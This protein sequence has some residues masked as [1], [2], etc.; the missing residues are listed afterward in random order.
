[1]AGFG[2]SRL[3][4]EYSENVNVFIPDCCHSSGTL[5]ALG[6]N[7]IH[8]SKGATLSPIDPSITGPLNPAVQ[9]NPVSAPQL[10]PLSVESVAGYYDLI[11]KSWRVN[12]RDD[13]LKVLAEKVHPLALGDVYRCRQQIEMLATQLL[14]QHRKDKRNI[15][16]IVQRLTKGLG[17]HDYL[18]YYKEATSLLIVRFPDLTSNQSFVA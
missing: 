5:F 7:K 9:S 13:L 18:I 3:L 8:M 6:A 14:E 16:R 17:S 1:M 10:I 12:N 15:I 2:L 11:S 4:R